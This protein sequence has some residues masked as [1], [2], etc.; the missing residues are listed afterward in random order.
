[1]DKLNPGD[2]ILYKSYGIIGRTIS[3][4]TR[5]PYS[6]VALAVDEDT[7]LESDRFINTRLS[8]IHS[9]KVVHHVYR[10]NG[11]TE[12]QQRNAVNYAMETIGT[13]YDY[14]QILG[15]FFRYVF[16]LKYL[17][18][19]SY[20]KFICSENIDY[21]FIRADIPRKD[22]EHLLDVSPQELLEKY[23]LRRVL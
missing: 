5:S 7:V 21:A 2:V 22:L 20:N 9:R 10:V 1:M 12:E 4:I 17:T 13:K 3:F 6:H 15:L 11:I 16:R 18:F 23:D 8:D 14:L 19:N